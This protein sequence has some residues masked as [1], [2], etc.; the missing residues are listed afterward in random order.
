VN[1]KRV[2]TMLRR[3]VLR[4]LV[5]LVMVASIVPVFKADV[6]AYTYSGSGFTVDHT[7]TDITQIPESYLAAAKQLLHIGYGHTS[8]GTQL[9]NGM[10][11]LVG[12]ANGGGRGLSFPTD[13]FEFNDGGTDGA[14]DLEEGSVELPSDNNTPGLWLEGDLTYYPRWVEETEEYLDAPE[15][16]DV[17]VII[18][19]WCNPLADSKSGY[20]LADIT[21]NYLE[22][23]N[24]LEA[25]YPNVTFVYM[26]S[27]LGSWDPSKYNIDDVRTANKVIR[28]YCETHDKILYDFEDIESWGPAWDTSSIYYPFVDDACNYY[29]SANDTTPDGNW[30]N[31]WEDSHTQG[32]PGGDWYYANGERGHTQQLNANLKAY[33]AWWLW[34]RLAGWDG[35][36]GSEVI[37]VTITDN[38]AAGLNFG[39][40]N[41]STGKSPEASSPSITIT[42][43]SENTRAAEIYLNGTNFTGAGTISIIN[44]FYNDTDN[45]STAMAMSTSYGSTP[46]KELAPGETL[47]IYHWLSIPAGTPAGDYTSTFRY[48]GQ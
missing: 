33:A 47:N 26:T 22:P 20:T 43:G 29:T 6:A 8:H 21:T 35:T 3:L 48:K 46:W 28:D 45:A 30:A 9:T 41:P 23:M 7:C 36:T 15:H 1:E 12:F 2:M 42:A 14:L 18:W 38:G 37:S 16:A 27:T 11:F 34:A 5:A 40:C 25:E 19:S 24:T 4:L 44:A 10:S 32:P 39:H 13:F 17:N 31:E